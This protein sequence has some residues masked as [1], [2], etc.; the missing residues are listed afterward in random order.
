MERKFGLEAVEH[1]ARA[2]FEI[3]DFVYLIGPIT[4][5]AASSGS[6][7]LMPP[8]ISGICAGPSGNTE[9]TQIGRADFNRPFT[10]E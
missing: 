3:E 5:A 1:P 2:G 8:A 6:S 7:S 4:W 9:G 10:C